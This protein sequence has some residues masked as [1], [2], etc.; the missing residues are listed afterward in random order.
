MVRRKTKGSNFIFEKE[1]ENSLIRRK[2]LY[3]SSV[4]LKLEAL[5]FIAPT[6]V[7]HF[8]CCKHMLNNDCKDR[9]GQK[10]KKLSNDVSCKICILLYNILAFVL[11]TDDSGYFIVSKTDTAG[12]YTVFFSMVW[13][14]SPSLPL[15]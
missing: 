5:T 2:I 14:S 3:E 4:I 6:V 8:E 13:V 7:V 15:C 10:K 1:E 9:R 11:V 12:G